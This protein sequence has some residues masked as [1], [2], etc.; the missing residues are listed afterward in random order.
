MSD[1]FL[2]F[3]QRLFGLGGDRPKQAQPAPPSKKNRP[4]TEAPARKASMSEDAL[5]GAATMRCFGPSGQL[6]RFTP[7]TAA[8]SSSGSSMN[9]RL[10]CLG[11]S[12]RCTR[13]SRRAARRSGRSR[14][15]VH[16]SAGRCRPLPSRATKERVVERH[17]ADTIHQKGRPAD[18]RRPR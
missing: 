9:S 7:R 2:H 3:L 6:L 16:G 10:L 8:R 18:S 4:S 14:S 15:A 17:V 11:S 1:G 12:S 5:R 13:C